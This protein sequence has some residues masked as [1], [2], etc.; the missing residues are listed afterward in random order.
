MKP[1]TYMEVM[2]ILSK[3]EQD[4]VN[5]VKS[6]GLQRD[7]KNF[8]ISSVYTTREIKKLFKEDWFKRCQK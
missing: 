1:Y 5:R 3:A 8:A 2:Q 4:Y 7:E 6:G